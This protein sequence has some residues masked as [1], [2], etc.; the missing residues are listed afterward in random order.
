MADRQGLRIIGFIAAS[1]TAA[2]MLIAIVLVHKTVAGELA[3]DAPRAAI[4]HTHLHHLEPTDHRL[5]TAASA[6]VTFLVS[7]SA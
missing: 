3:F 7:G 6:I 5:V 2:V 4:S 1:V